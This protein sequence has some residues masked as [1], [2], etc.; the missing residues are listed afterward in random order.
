[1]KKL[2][3]FSIF[4][5][6]GISLSVQS[7]FSQNPIDYFYIN[8]Y[9]IINPTVSN[10]IKITEMDFN[11]W[12]K[13]LKELGYTKQGVWDDMVRYATGDFSETG[14]LSASKSQ[15]KLL[16]SFFWIPV[17]PQNTI[18]DDLMNELTPYY[19]RTDRVQ[20]TDDSVSMI[21]EMELDNGNIYRFVL[22]RKQG[23]ENL[24]VVRIK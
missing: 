20:G 22:S 2:Y 15:I 8:D 7:S 16:I 5:I 9:K 12:E 4:I 23:S 18:Y 24:M 14:M 21:F 3:F 10:L 17:K 11:E 1:M 19:V 13:Y 6:M